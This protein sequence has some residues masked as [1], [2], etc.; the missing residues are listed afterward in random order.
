M[1]RTVC[2]S[3]RASFAAFDAAKPDRRQPDIAG[4]ARG[5]LQQRPSCVHLKRVGCN[6]HSF[7]ASTFC[8]ALASRL[9]C[10]RFLLC[11]WRALFLSRLGY[12]DLPPGLFSMMQTQS[13]RSQAEL[14]GQL[15]T[16]TCAPRNHRPISGR[17][18]EPAARWINQPPRWSC[19][20]SRKS[21]PPD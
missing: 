3:F 6:C 13:R 11:S 4:Q 7:S 1:V 17:Y 21:L 2:R 12:V 20:R 5:F 15:A 9:F 14:A 10:M 8:M 19:V 18:T 16:K